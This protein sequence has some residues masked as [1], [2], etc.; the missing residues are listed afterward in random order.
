MQASITTPAR[1][2]DGEEHRKQGSDEDELQEASGQQVEDTIEHED[3]VEQGR[4]V[5]V[6]KA[7][8]V[9][10]VAD[11][12][13]EEEAEGEEAEEHAVQGDKQLAHG[14]GLYRDRRS[15]GGVWWTWCGV[16]DV[17]GRKLRWVVVIAGGP[18]KVAC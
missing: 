12:Q 17:A 16:V 8:A 10:H 13:G 3:R 9:Q 15:R 7:E 4:G 14:L 1:H 6:Q 2:E 11:V 18:C 5:K